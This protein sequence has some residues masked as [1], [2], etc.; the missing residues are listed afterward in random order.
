MSPLLRLLRLISPYLWWIISGLL[1]SFATIGSNIGLITVSAYLISKAAITTNVADLALAITGVR[2]FAISRA[3]FR[4]LERVTTHTATF[5]ILTHLRVWLYRSIEPLAPARLHAYRSGDLLARIV[6]D[7]E[8]LENFYVRAVI[9]PLAAALVTG[10]ACALL[11]SFD[12]RLGLALLV[13]LALTGIALPL[14][15]RRLSRL[16]SRELVHARAELTAG[17]VD[18]IQGLADLLAF[19]QE[20][21]QL[22]RLARLNQESERAQERLAWIRGLGDGLA[23]LFTGLCGLA[24]LCLA[25]PLV[26]NSQIDGVY[27]ALL[28]LAAIASFE[29]AQPLA[30]AL[31]QTQASQE[32]AQRLFELI[33]A[34]PPV[35]DPFYPTPKPV[36]SNLVV[37]ELS[38]R[39]TPEEPLVLQS[40]SFQLPI[41]GRLAIVG[42]SGAGKSTLVNLLLRFWDYAEGSL[43]LGGQELHDLSADDARAMFAVVSQHTH[44]FNVTVR[45]DLRLANSDAS[46]EQ[47]MAACRTAQVHDFIQTLPQGYDTLI[48]ENGFLLSAGQRQRLAIARALL[49]P[50]PVLLLDEP[51]ANLDPITERNLLQSI[52]DG[53]RE[54][55]ILL[56]THR[57][58]GLKNIDDIIVLQDGEI[59]QRGTH[60]TLST[61]QGLYRQMWQ[62]QSQLLFESGNLNPDL[63]QVK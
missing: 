52:L 9:P 6:S 5:R 26:S 3:A 45:D 23:A 34:A 25:I 27:L 18:Q 4:Y 17:L 63:E 8:T 21:S 31:G 44:L 14:Y 36:E 40:L 19:G 20:Y 56:I 41:G 16:P 1:L 61:Q 57:L 58:A 51:T 10:L 46:D 15:T 50:A 54:R 49:K 13:F 32:A 11:G 12:L 53:S 59:V 60:A 2:L 48:G 29:A 37:K 24:V 30:N 39:Y 62:A 38:F 42:P 33:D 22:E 47:I 7:I 28:P 55:S 35:L 43:Q